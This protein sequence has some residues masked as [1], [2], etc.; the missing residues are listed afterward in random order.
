MFLFCL[1]NYLLANVFLFCFINYLLPNVYFIFS[2]LANGEIMF[3]QPI[4]SSSPTP[5]PSSILFDPP[6]LPLHSTPHPL[7]FL[8]SCLFRATSVNLPPPLPLMIILTA[9]LRFE[10]WRYFRPMRQP[11]W[12]FSCSCVHPIKTI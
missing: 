8:P 4:I 12:W 10:T 9:I 11:R 2:L 1:I 7:P 3:C 5:N 6:P